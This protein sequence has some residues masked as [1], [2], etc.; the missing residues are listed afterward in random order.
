[1]LSGIT[2]FC[3]DI[4]EETRGTATIVGALPDNIYLTDTKRIAEARPVLAHQLSCRRR[5][6]NGDYGAPGAIR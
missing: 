2:I 4:R 1:M 3:E 6:T 5:V